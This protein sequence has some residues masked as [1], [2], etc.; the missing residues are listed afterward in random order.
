MQISRNEKE[1][2]QL[3]HMNELLESDCISTFADGKYTNKV[4][5]CIMT[6]ITECN[7]RVNKISHVIQTVLRKLANKPERKYLRIELMFNGTSTQKNKE[8]VKIIKMFCVE[9]RFNA[10]TKEY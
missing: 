6:L 4:R 3:H 10:K 9:N 5:Q 7:I 1:I 8:N 2:V